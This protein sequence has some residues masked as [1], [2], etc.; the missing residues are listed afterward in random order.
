MKDLPRDKQ[1][2]TFVQLRGNY[3]VHGDLVDP[4][5]PQAFHRYQP[6]AVNT[7]SNS[8]QSK[9]TRLDL[10]HWLMQKDNPLTA[11]VIANRYWE[12]LFGTGI[13]KTSEEFWL[14]R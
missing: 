11:R 7:E 6:D 1:R 13:V 14:S 3:K 8:K 4:G 9:L 12:N 10:A 2:Q 5:L